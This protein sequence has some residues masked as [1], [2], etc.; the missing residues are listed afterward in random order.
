MYQ[1]QQKVNGRWTVYS[2]ENTF[3]EAQ[4]TKAYLDSLKKDAQ[5]VQEDFDGWINETDCG[6]PRM[7]SAER[8]EVGVIFRSLETGL[9][10]FAV[11]HKTARA[12]ADVTI[13]LNSCGE[14]ESKEICKSL[15][16]L[17]KL[18]HP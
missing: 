16:T 6:C 14:Q 1:I 11:S 2:T 17:N 3:N 10:L 7:T 15:P 8:T 18:L 9:N 12:L 5:V 13:A 4:V